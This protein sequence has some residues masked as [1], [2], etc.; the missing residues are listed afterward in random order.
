MA[1]EV[2]QLSEQMTVVA[3]APL[4]DT[5]TVS[6]GQN[7]D[8]HMVEALP[9]FSNIPIMQSRFTRG[10]VPAEVRGYEFGRNL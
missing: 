1:L 2:G 7:Y 3:E 9:M 10:V 6:S 8:R 4:L 5:S